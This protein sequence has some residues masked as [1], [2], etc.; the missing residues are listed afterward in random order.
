[1][2]FTTVLVGVFALLTTALANPA[3][4]RAGIDG[5]GPDWASTPPASKPAGIDGSGPDW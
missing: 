1:M 3:S 4:K 5:S 2:R